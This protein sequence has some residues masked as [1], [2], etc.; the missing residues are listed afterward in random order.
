MR[1][2]SGT[3]I[4]VELSDARYDLVAPGLGCHGELVEDTAEIRPVLDRAF[5]AGRLPSRV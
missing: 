1:K 2:T 5:A 4:G 3:T